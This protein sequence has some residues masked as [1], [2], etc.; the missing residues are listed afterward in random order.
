M[1]SVFS[2]EPEGNQQRQQQA[3]NA[4]Q[5]HDDAHGVCVQ[6]I[7]ERRG[8][9]EPQ[10]HPGRDQNDADE[11]ADHPPAVHRHHETAIAHLCA[12]LRPAKL[13]RLEASQAISS[14][15]DSSISDELTRG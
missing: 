12:V 3:K 7:G 2:I 1:S 6:A 8:D 5:H 10:D 11:G 15:T 13:V 9:G 4:G 14:I